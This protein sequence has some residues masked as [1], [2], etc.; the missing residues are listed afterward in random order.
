METVAPE[1]A[2]VP[3]S[4]SPLANLRAGLLVLHVDGSAKRDVER[5][6][7]TGEPERQHR[8]PRLLAFGNDAVAR[9]ALSRRPLLFPDNPRLHEPA[10]FHDDG[11]ERPRPRQPGRTAARMKTCVRTG[12]QWA[13][14]CTLGDAISVHRPSSRMR[15]G[16]EM[17]ATS[18]DLGNVTGQLGRSTSPNRV[19]TPRPT[20]WVWVPP[21]V[22][23]VT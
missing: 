11:S 3:D 7:G 2:P 17:S 10:S 23:K 20:S 19:S 14:R 12:D 4:R 15:D 22:P 5:T 13:R 16:Y 6:N 18:S 8:R 9:T 21:S 1:L